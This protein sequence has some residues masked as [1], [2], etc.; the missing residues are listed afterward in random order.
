MMAASKVPT[1]AP[2]AAYA[3]FTWTCLSIMSN[4]IDAMIGLT[5]N[6]LHDGLASI[7]RRKG[8]GR[9]YRPLRRFSGN[10]IPIVISDKFSSHFTS[11]TLLALLC[12]SILRL[13][14][15][16]AYGLRVALAD[17]ASA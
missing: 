12:M 2:S 6:P 3:R 1:S 8:C 5:K 7:P 16:L 10:S 11:G 13:H 17:T 14:P 15:S 9:S 4:R